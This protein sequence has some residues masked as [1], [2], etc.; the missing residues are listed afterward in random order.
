MKPG[1]LDSGFD[2]RRYIKQHKNSHKYLNYKEYAGIN[3][4]ATAARFDLNSVA[5]VG[6][7]GSGAWAIPPRESE[8][9]HS[10]W[11]FSARS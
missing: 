3:T 8:P 2:G 9:S 10:P 4:K 5:I 6:R 1:A 11:A 7:L